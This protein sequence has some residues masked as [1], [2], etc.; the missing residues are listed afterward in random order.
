M[1]PKADYVNSSVLTHYA[2][3]IYDWLI[4]WNCLSEK[5]EGIAETAI[6][7]VMITAAVRENFMKLIPP[8]I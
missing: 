6:G 7:K 5:G 4:P 3:Q 8:S 2:Y 1:L